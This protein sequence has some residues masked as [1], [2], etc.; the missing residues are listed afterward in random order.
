M[1]CQNALTNNHP[2]VQNMMGIQSRAAVISNH[3]A[4]STSRKKAAPINT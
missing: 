1:I 4:R 3:G 2:M